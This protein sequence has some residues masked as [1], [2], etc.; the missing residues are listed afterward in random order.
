MKKKI[1]I[2][3]T[4]FLLLIIAYFWLAPGSSQENSDL[5]ITAEKGTFQIDITTSGELEA[6]NSVKIPG[7]NVRSVGIWQI[8][9]DN[10]VE[11]GTLVKK[12]DY[13]AT[14]DKSELSTKMMNADTE[15]QKTSSQFS[16]AQLDSAL[17][18]RQARDELIN[19]KYAVTERQIVVEQSQFEPPATI[20]QAEID[21]EKAERAYQQAKENYKIKLQQAKAKMQEVAA[22]LARAER[23][24]KTMQDL[25]QSFTITAPEEG[26]VVYVRDWNGSRR[27]TGSQISAF[28]PIVA[29]LPDLTTMISKTYINEVDIRKISEGQK[30]MIGLDAFPEKRLTGSVM[31][32]SNVGEQKPN[33]DAKVY[34]V[35]IIINESDTT[36]R[37]A[38]TTSNTIISEVLEDAIFIPL[39]CL[40]S[41]G[42]T[43]TYVY[44][45][46]GLATLRQEVKIG[47]SN[48]NEVVIHAGL[49]EGEKIYLSRP[50]G[51]DEGKLVLL[52]ETP[53]TA[54]SH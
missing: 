50:K 24:L 5:F 25:I 39:E 11:E 4:I 53:T 45:Q 35:N 15:L 36:L 41:Q 37:P 21:K 38:M 51:N 19:L 54:S 14:L 6:K 42:D 33:S 49:N 10:L 7:P 47:K 22:N 20:K 30:V 9:I 40:H 17:T 31:S 13:I 34:Q 48:T 44:K 27:A 12:G 16:Q 28:D 52:E 8:K 26:M 2:P 46:D 23:D 3:V 32:V 1:I 29:T 18:L 43:L